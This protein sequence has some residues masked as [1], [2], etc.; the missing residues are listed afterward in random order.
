MQP[1]R[2][3]GSILIA[4]ALAVMLGVA[5]MAATGCQHASRTLDFRELSEET[6]PTPQYFWPLTGLEAPDSLIINRRPISVKIDNDP[7]AFPQEGLIDADLVYEIE[8]EG[9]IS[10][11]HAIFQSTLPN[12]AGPVRSA[13][14]SDIWV[15]G[16]WDSYLMYSGAAMHVENALSTAGI[17]R[18]NEKRD[19]RIWERVSDRWA[20]HNLFVKPVN[21]PTTAAEY[22]I[23]T[24]WT[25]RALE[26]DEASFEETPTVTRIVAPIG[27][28]QASEWRWDEIDHTY[29]RWQREVEHVDAVTDR[30]INADNVVVL[31]ANIEN[32]DVGGMVSVFKSGVRFDGTWTTLEDGSLHLVDEAGQ[33]LL[34]N[35]GKTWFQIVGM[36]SEVT[37]EPLPLDEPVVVVQ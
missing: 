16:Q 12:Q 5:A 27:P 1:M 4:V 28:A 29:Y 10:R 19:E 26:F 3:Q 15:I 24:S 32:L 31:W 34:L 22:S 17:E 21:V 23:E 18:I 7:N 6:T 35:P 14:L 30:Q 9:G 37:V 33:L 20:P 13:R 11:F 25:L 36:W 2:R 8:A